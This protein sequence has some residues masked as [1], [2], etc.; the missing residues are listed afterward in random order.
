MVDIL[1]ALTTVAEVS[2]IIW[3]V[4]FAWLFVMLFRK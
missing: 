1:E 4:V 3:I 2:M